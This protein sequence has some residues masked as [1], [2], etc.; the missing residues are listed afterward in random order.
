M[1]VSESVSNCKAGK[2]RTTSFHSWDGSTEELLSELIREEQRARQNS[3]EVI[4]EKRISETISA[5]G[6]K[7]K[8]F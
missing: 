4:S 6:D 1:C 3:L 8:R 2:C 5:S 7:M